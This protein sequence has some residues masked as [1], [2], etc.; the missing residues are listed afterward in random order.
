[1]AKKKPV[2]EKPIKPSRDD[3]ARQNV[4]EHID[5][6]RAIAEKLRRKIN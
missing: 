4:H 1:M 3:E 6:Q 2:E 5:D